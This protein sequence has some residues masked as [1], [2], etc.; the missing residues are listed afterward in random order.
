M[1]APRSRRGKRKC[2]NMSRVA[3]GYGLVVKGDADGEIA[4]YREALRLNPNDDMEHNNL[5]VSLRDKGDLDG[6]IA[7]YLEALRLNPNNDLAHSNHESSRL[8]RGR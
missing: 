1:L 4:E 2:C 8:K 6:A 7:D 5:G 3:L